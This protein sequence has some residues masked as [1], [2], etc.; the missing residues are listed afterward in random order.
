MIAVTLLVRNEQDI[1]EANIVYHLNAGADL[2]LVTDH[3]STD[4]TGAILRSLSSTGQVRY[5][6]ETSPEFQQALWVT[7]MARE[8]A[9]CGADWVIN[10]AADEFWWPKMGDLADTFASVPRHVSLLV[11]H[12]YDYVAV[13]GDTGSFHET[14]IYRKSDSTNAL[15][16]PLP[17]KVT[18]RAAPDV[19]VAF[20]NHTATSPGFGGMLDDDRIE[21]FHFPIRCYDQFKNKVL[22]GT[23][24]LESTAGIDPGIGSTWR[25]L[26]DAHTSGTLK[27]KFDAAMLAA[28][29]VDTLL[30]E[31]MI[32]RD[33]R[34]RDTIRDIHA[35]RS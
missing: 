33:T 24:A 3:N 16:Q 15:G 31:G 6:L 14:N 18:H 25:Y 17:P 35:G 20:G 19:E 13:H 30:T 7:A 21:I 27:Q 26:R 34:L 28:S 1:I 8:A 2:V 10:S 9:R 11:T 5:R 4:N 29:Q 22:S 23:T 32:T 12:R